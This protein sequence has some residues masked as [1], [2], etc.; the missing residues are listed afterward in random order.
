M[1]NRRKEIELSGNCPSL[2]ETLLYYA[3]SI[4]KIVIECCSPVLTGLKV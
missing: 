4:T 2:T 1:S 3:T